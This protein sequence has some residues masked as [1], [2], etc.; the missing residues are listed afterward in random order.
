MLHFST[1][2][3]RIIFT[4]LLA[5]YLTRKNTPKNISPS[6]SK[7]SPSTNTSTT[8]KKASL[9][10]KEGIKK[11]GPR[12]FLLYSCLCLSTHF[13]IYGLIRYE[14]IS[15]KRMEAKIKDTR[16]EKSYDWIVS[17]LGDRG[18]D[19]ALAFAINELGEPIRLPT[20]FV[21]AGWYFS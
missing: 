17:K 19:F 10:S 5:G 12:G 13:I 3:L 1:K 7:S 6:I 2:P 14:Y 11:Y 18:T 20:F 4:C 8:V 15:R 9:F 16:V 21:L